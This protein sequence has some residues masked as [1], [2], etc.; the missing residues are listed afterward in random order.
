MREMVPLLG[1]GPRPQKDDLSQIKVDLANKPNKSDALTLE[2]IE[3]S[4]DLTGKIA[5][6]SAVKDSNGTIKGCLLW[7]N[8]NTT[9]SFPKQTIQ[10]DLSQYA[11]IGVDFKRTKDVDSYHAFFFSRKDVMGTC[12][13]NYSETNIVRYMTASDTG[14][15]FGFAGKFTASTEDTG[16]MIPVKIY[17]YRGE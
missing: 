5:S 7:E 2:E 17:G 9:S 13:T 8:A 14:V 11:Y 16:Y 1:F 10:L 12:I 15:Y 6:A 4:E 3:E